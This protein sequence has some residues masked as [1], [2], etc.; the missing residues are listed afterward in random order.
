MN[1]KRERHSLN[2]RILYRGPFFLL[3]ELPA[4]GPNG[5]TKKWIILEHPGAAAAVPI[6]PGGRVA[7]VRQFRP[8]IGKETLEIPAGKLET[9]ES[10]ET[11]LQR[12]LAEEI[13][14]R[15]GHL[16]H[17]ASF[18]PSFGISSEII[19][20][21]LATEMTEAKAQS[22]DESAIETVILPLEEAER[23]IASGEITDAKTIIGFAAARDCLKD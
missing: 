4:A 15:A 2:S 12:E 10:A 1:K 23:L 20:V 8:A 6:L 3:R 18:H 7:L 17:L 19:H 11:C 22:R 13:G 5:K 21:F 9:G 14:F 16:R